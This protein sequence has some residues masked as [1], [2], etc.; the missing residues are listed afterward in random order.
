MVSMDE[1][2]TLVKFLRNNTPKFYRKNSKTTKIFEFIL[3]LT[4]ACSAPH[5]P[6]AASAI[7]GEGQAAQDMLVASEEG[8]VC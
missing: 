5:T 4:T 7:R 6:V 2:K 3:P 8:E 1:E